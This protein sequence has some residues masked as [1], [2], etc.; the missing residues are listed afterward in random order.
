MVAWFLPLNS[1]GDVESGKSSLEQIALLSSSLWL[2]LIVAG[3]RDLYLFFYGL[4]AWA[5]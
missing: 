5:K 4:F 1:F 3:G 2:M